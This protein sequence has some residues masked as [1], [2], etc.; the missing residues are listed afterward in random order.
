MIAIIIASASLVVALISLI[1]TGTMA[2][3]LRIIG[4]RTDLVLGEQELMPATLPTRGQP[5]H[6]VLGPLIEATVETTTGLAVMRDEFLCDDGCILIVSTSCAACRY[7][8]HQCR[9]LLI[10]ESVRT[11]VVAQATE[12]GKEFVEQDCQADGIAYQ[13]DP[14]GERARVLGIAEFPSALIVRGG[15]ISAAYIIG[16]PGQLR[17]VCETKGSDMTGTRR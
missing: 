5:V 1:A 9:D 13:V 10:G 11:L 2:T 14:A 12:R 15:V 7:L 6:E 4:P 8:V 3:R 16:S 17:A